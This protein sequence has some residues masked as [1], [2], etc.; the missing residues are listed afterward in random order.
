LRSFELIRHALGIRFYNTG[1]SL[2]SIISKSKINRV[3][4]IFIEGTKTNGNG[5]LKLSE[6][7]CSQLVD[8]HLHILRFDFVFKYFSPYNTTDRCGCKFLLKSLAEITHQMFVY[9]TLNVE[10]S[11]DT[12]INLIIERISKALATKKSQYYVYY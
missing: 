12:K 2:S 11:A 9:Y 10:I 8:Y 3:I 4:V 1:D 5:V 6:T 7:L